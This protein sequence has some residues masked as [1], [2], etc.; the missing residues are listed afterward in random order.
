M[1]ESVQETEQNYTSRSL[2]LAFISIDSYQ[3]AEVLPFSRQSCISHGR[4]FAPYHVGVDLDTMSQYKAISGFTLMRLV[5][6][7]NTI[8]EF[9]REERY[10]SKSKH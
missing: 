9:V 7:A 8:N 2:Y 4:N 5:R 1:E 3:R 6:K 10:E